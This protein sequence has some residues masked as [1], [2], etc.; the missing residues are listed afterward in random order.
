MRR[1]IQIT[2]LAGLICLCLASVVMVSFIYS[3]YDKD[4]ETVKD[5]QYRVQRVEHQVDLSNR[6]E[7]RLITHLITTTDGA[8]N[9]YVCI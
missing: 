7:T 3:K 9:S 2:L 4:S 1:T 8:T 6:W 5:L